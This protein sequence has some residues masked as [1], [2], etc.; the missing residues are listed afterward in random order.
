MKNSSLCDARV[1]IL[2]S[3]IQTLYTKPSFHREIQW[4]W[5]IQRKLHLSSSITKA[6]VDKLI[7]KV[8]DKFECFVGCFGVDSWTRANPKQWQRLLGFST[9]LVD[10][11]NIKG[12][13]SSYIMS[14]ARR[15]SQRS[16]CAAESGRGRGNR[17]L[18]PDS[19]NNALRTFP[20]C[21]FQPNFPP[22]EP[23]T[24]NKAILMQFQNGW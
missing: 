14:R 23:G 19:G 24:F 17:T 13:Q 20:A 7:R 4:L 9:Q 8:F 6:T 12:A 1:H 3:P 18:Y 2:I 21:A 11:E 5:E 22:T 10:S 16:R 15:G